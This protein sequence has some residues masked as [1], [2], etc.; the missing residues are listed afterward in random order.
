[1]TPAWRKDAFLNVDEWQ[2]K[3]GKPPYNDYYAKY[4]KRLFSKDFYQT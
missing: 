4:Y 3:I 1:M 2:G